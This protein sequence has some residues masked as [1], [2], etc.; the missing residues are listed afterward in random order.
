[1]L[2]FRFGVPEIL[3]GKKG[4]QGQELGKKIVREK[5]SSTNILVSNT[6]FLGKIADSRSVVENTQ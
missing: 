6:I 1:M 4:G 3:R 2:E 5:Y